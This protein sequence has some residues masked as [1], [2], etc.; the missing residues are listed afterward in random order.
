M[1]SQ[2]WLCFRFML[3]LTG[4][5]TVQT[6]VSQTTFACDGDSTF[7][8]NRGENPPY[9]SLNAGGDVN[10]VGINSNPGGDVFFQFQYGC[11]PLGQ[12]ANRI[13]QRS[14]SWSTSAISYDAVGELTYASLTGS[15]LTTNHYSFDR[16]S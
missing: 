8:A 12:I 6:S 4:C 7:A 14:A 13:N 3:V 16:L 1:T 9:R 2:F 5:F 11:N 15:S 10:Y